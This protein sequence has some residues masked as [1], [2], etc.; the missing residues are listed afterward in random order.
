[1]TMVYVLVAVVVLAV[2]IFLV[3]RKPAQPT[4]PEAKKPEALEAKKAKVKEEEE[5]R[6]R[7]RPIPKT[8]KETPSAKREEREA[9]REVRVVENPRPSVARSPKRTS[10][11][12]AVFDPATVRR[13]LA[14]TRGGLIARLSDL[15]RGRKVVDPALLSEI[16]EVLLTSDVGVKTTQKRFSGCTSASRTTSSTTPRR[17]GQ[18]SAPRPRRSSARAA[19]SSSAH[20]PT[21]VLM[22]GVNG[23]GKTTTI[24]KLATKLKAEGKKVVLAAGDTF[25]AAAVQQL[26]V[27][28]K[29]VGAEVVQGQGG[30]RSRRRAL[31]R[32]Q[33]G[34]G[35]RA[36]TSSS[37]T[38]PAAF[39]RRR[40]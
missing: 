37:S 38:P 39:T 34:E 36:P 9:A 12:P 35:D 5:E 14:R 7:A 40:T 27:W 8:I 31:R 1:M 24:G 3:T 20:K 28:G 2:I 18:R 26:E 17:S 16:E 21:V 23:V 15:I 19:A 13:G 29:R 33:E 30:R 32:D 6:P 25:R 4:L 11:S 22:V 10:A